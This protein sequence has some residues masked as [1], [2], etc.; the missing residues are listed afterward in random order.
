MLST[1]HWALLAA[2]GTAQSEVLTRITIFLTLVSAGL[3][4]IGLLGQASQFAG[5]FATAALSILGALAVVGVLTQLRVEAVAEEDLMYV[6]AM[7]RLRGAYVEL[8]PSI[9]P[10]L[11]TSPHDDEAGMSHTYSFLRPRSGAAQ[12]LASSA[13]LIILVNG[14]VVGLLGG[15]IAAVAGLSNGG[16]VAVGAIAA[17]SVPLVSFAN[18]WRNYLATWRNHTPMFPTAGPGD[19]AEADPTAGKDDEE[20][21]G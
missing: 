3:V 8:D 1:E 6:V 14:I 13:V 19:V 9:R 5:W 18:T 12:M 21:D 2:R 17:V 7:N 20:P 11:M 4:T 15:G 16:A 10:Y